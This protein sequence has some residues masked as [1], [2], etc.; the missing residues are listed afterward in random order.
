MEAAFEHARME[1]PS[2]TALAA[3]HDRVELLTALAE[4]FGLALIGI[5][6]DRLLTLVTPTQSD[7]SRR[8][9]GT[10]SV[11]E[12]VALAGAGPGARL[13]L[14]RLIGP[15]RMATCAVAIGENP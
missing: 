10:G 2:I 3:P 13:L 1:V 8:A 11:A 4:W 15:D 14:P 7:H 12:A 6:S 9:R 5:P